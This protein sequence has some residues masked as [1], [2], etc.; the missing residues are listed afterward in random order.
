M[1]NPKHFGDIKV[2]KYKKYF[3]GIKI[4]IKAERKI[5]IDIKDQFLEAI[6][7]FGFGV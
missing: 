1:S 7:M 6:E 5:E 3:L 4:A 2:T